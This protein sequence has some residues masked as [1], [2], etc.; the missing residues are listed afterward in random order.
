[1]YTINDF[2]KILQIIQGGSADD[3]TEAVIALAKNEKTSAD[4]LFSTVIDQAS[5]ST[6]DYFGLRNFIRDLYASHRT[7]TTYQTSISDLYSV[8]LHQ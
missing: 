4:K 6:S 8:L 1:M 7:L 2:W 5:F 3:I